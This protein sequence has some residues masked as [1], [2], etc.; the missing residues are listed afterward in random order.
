MEEIVP[1]SYFQPPEKHFFPSAKNAKT[2]SEF[3]VMNFVPNIYQVCVPRDSPG[4]ELSCWFPYSR[5]L[6]REWTHGTLSSVGC[7]YRRLDRS[8][9]WLGEL[10][11]PE[12]GL[13]NLTSVPIDLYVRA[14]RTC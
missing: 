5:S 1:R 7:S 10:L 14:Q 6:L 4:T 12:A 9:R 8:R 13:L 2:I 11:F 3:V